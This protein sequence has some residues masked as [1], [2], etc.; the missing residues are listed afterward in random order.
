LYLS[1]WLISA[2]PH[3]G[4]FL[5]VFF[6]HSK[7]LQGN[8]AL[9]DEAFTLMQKNYYRKKSLNWDSLYQAAKER[10]SAADNCQDIYDII[11]WSFRQ[12][13]ETHSLLCR[14]KGCCL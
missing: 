8:A 4:F 2:E 1:A 9:L 14:H 5:P 11:D 3:T 12:I 13:D 7:W 6:R 10:L